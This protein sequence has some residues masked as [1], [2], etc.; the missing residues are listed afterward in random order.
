MSYSTKHIASTLRTARESKGLSQRELS[1]KSGIPQ[2]HISKIE[3]GAVD[4]RVS[5]LVALARALDVELTLVPRKIVPAVQSIVRSSARSTL[6]DGEVAR[7]SQRALAR[8]QKTISSL[9]ETASFAKEVT[10]LQRQVRELQRFQLATPDI[11]ALRAVNK[12]VKAFRNDTKNLGGIRQALP[13]L[14]ELRNALVH[15]SVNVPQIA[16]ARPAYSLD[17]DDHG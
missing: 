6:Q 10:Q 7:Q 17:V 15:S 16:S 3:N 5:S 4:L 12:A 9:P 11:E 14:R 8:I 1:A 13:Q 2:G